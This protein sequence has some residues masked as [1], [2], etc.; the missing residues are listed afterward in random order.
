[1]T[2]DEFPDFP[3]DTDGYREPQTDFID[4][5]VF[6]GRQAQRLPVECVR[7]SA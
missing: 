4:D 5:I 6:D 7:R 1:M 3:W 2:A